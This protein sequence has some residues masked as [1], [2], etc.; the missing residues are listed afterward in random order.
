MKSL[1]GLMHRKLAY[2]PRIAAL[3]ARIA[4][5]I[6][7]GQRLL[8]VGCGSGSLARALAAQVPGLHIE[9]AERAPRGQEGFPVH[10]CDAAALPVGDKS[11]DVVVVA[12]MLHHDRQPLNILKECGRVARSLVIVKD[13]LRRGLFSYW[14]ICLLDW[15]ANTPYGVPC[16]F[17]YHNMNEWRTILRDANLEVVSIADR[18][19]LYHWLV[20]WCFG[21]GL[22]ILIVARPAAAGPERAPVAGEKGGS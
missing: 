16:L 18:M 2:E 17:R 22:H 1:I 13:H 9:G 10:R 3:S 11:F 8:D 12:D 4:A 5:H 20:N 21:K 15:A 19:D 14:R 6:G 7:P